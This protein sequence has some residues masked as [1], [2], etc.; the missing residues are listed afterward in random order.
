MGPFSTSKMELLVALVNGF[1][2]LTN[3]MKNSISDVAT[4]LDQAVV[5]IHSFFN[6]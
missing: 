2:P 4:V 3:V 5:T 6:H 1:V